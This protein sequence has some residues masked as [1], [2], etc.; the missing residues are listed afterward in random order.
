MAKVKLETTLGEIV[1]NLDE[2]RAPISTKNFL[3]YMESKHYEGTLFH[4]VID[5]F[6]IQGGGYDGELKKKP[7]RPPIENEAGNGLENKRGTVAMARTSDVQSATAQF[8]INV[9][10][11]A[12]L[13]HRDDSPEGFGYAVFGEVVEGM[14]VVDKIKSVPT[15]G[16][17]SF[18]K[19][20]PVE[21][22]RIISVTRI[23]S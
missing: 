23:D 5:G 3:E 2:E 12:F 16:R 7:T 15:G 19:D 6:M 1:L 21:D 13:N 22:V 11:N 8:F 9:V 18:A 4:R 14:E 17:G 10:D 20:V